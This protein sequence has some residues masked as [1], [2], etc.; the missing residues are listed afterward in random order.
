MMRFVAAI[1]VMPLGVPEGMPPGAQ[2]AAM[3]RASWGS[4]PVAAA[5]TEAE[6][7]DRKRHSIPSRSSQRFRRTRRIRSKTPA[8]PEVRNRR[9]H[10]RPELHSQGILFS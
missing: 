5:E 4:L 7:N 10:V 2:S 9:G 1:D 3:D 6:S 8:R